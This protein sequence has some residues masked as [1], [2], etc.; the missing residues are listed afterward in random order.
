MRAKPWSLKFVIYASNGLALACGGGPATDPDGPPIGSPDART[1]PAGDAS[2]DAVEALPPVVLPRCPGAT[3]ETAPSAAACD[4]KRIT[5]QR[6]LEGSCYGPD[7]GA[8]C[9]RL[10][11]EV[12]AGDEGMLP[13]G[14]VCGA[15]DD[16]V[17]TC[18]WT[19][20]DASPYTIDAAALEAACAVTIAL[21]TANVVCVS[22]GS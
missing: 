19:F 4:P 11:V 21:P 15:A 7:V 16:A 8:G 10:E 22:S 2:V 12:P 3:Y 5:R 14:F 1:G 6:G 9:Q 13:A 18:A 17:A 20:D